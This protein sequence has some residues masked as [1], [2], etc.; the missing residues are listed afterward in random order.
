MSVRFD[1][2]Q[3]CPFCGKDSVLVSTFGDVSAWRCM[4]PSCDYQGCDA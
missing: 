2:E 1:N 3:P 4:I